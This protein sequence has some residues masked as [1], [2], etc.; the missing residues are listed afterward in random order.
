[1][2]KSFRGK[3]AD[4]E[5]KTI[6]LS[7][8]NGLTGY[9]IVK[10]KIIEQ[11]PGVGNTESLVQVY[12]TDTDETNT[13]RTAST[14]IDFT[15]PTL[16]AVAFWNTNAST[17]TFNEAIIFDN[18]KFN[19]DIYIAHKDITASGETINYYIELEQVKLSH[20]EAAVAT[21]KDMRAGPDTRF[22]P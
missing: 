14:T 11:T 12:T 18:V 2:I 5:L 4:G 19:Q 10:F 22:G 15:D 6:R 9:R 3:L 20:D 16:L 13:L 1:M 17:A 21:L 8:N 7:T